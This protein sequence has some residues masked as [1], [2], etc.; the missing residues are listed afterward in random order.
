MA[1]D[2]AEDLPAAVE[3]QA[4]GSGLFI[5]ILLRGIPHG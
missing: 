1:V 4:H 2:S 3:R 5:I